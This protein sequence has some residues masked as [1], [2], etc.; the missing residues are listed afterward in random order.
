M[1]VPSSRT[2]ASSATAS[3]RMHARLTC[4]STS[5]RALTL[6]ARTAMPLFP[7]S[8][9]N[10]WS[11]SGSQT[12]IRTRSCRHRTPT[13]NSMTARRSSSA[14]GLK[15]EPSTRITGLSFRPPDHQS[16]TLQAPPF[17]TRSTPLLR[18]VLPGQN[19]CNHPKP[20]A[21]PSHAVSLSTCA[22]SLPPRK[23]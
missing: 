5:R 20:R 9:P 4:V 15:K 16:P 13:S 1:S 12:W 21:I 7:A 6:S 2:D 3:T 11:G 19:S 23:N 8:Q 22:V 10:P 18:H 17:T 14:A